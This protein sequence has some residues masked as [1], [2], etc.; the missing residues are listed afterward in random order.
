[1]CYLCENIVVSI[2]GFISPKE[3][4]NC[5]STLWLHRTSQSQGPSP[6]AGH[7][8]RG[9]LGQ[10]NLQT[11][12]THGLPR[13]GLIANQH[14]LIWKLGKGL[15]EEKEKFCFRCDAQKTALNN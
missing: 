11:C 12:G 4:T 1:M 6:G 14:H 13:E 2:F 15:K 7:L 3:A 10:V 8:T 5:V 9:Q